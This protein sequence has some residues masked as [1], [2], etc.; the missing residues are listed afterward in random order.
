MRFCKLDIIFIVMKDRQ[1]KKGG[2][3]GQQEKEIRRR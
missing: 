1:K 3:K 2:E